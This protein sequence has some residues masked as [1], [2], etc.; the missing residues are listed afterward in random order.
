MSTHQHRSGSLKQANKG[1]KRSHS[2]K[3]ALK[4]STPGRVDTARRRSVKQGDKRNGSLKKKNR[5]KQLKQQKLERLR[6]ERR[7]GGG[8]N[9][10][11][12]V[13]ILPL[14]E[15]VD[16][17]SLCSGLVSSTGTKAVLSPLGH[18]T[19]HSSKLKSRFT[20]L[21]VV[22][23]VAAVLDAAKAADVL[24][25]VLPA[26]HGQEHCIDQL[27]DDCIS[28]LRSQGLPTVIC[29]TTGLK[30]LPPKRA[31]E[32]RRYGQRLFKTEFGEDV[33]ILEEGNYFQVLRALADARLKQMK[34]RS[35]RPYIA[36]DNLETVSEGIDNTSGEEMVTVR[37]SGY[38]RGAAMTPNQLVHITDVGT[39]KLRQIS[40]PSDPC[41]HNRRDL[42]SRNKENRAFLADPSIVNDDLLRSEAVPTD[43]GCEQTWPTEQEM[44]MNYDDGESKSDDGLTRIENTVEEIMEEE[45]V[46]IEKLREAEAEDREFEDEVDTPLDQPAAERF[47]RYR[48]LKSF[49]T[50]P[51]DVKESLPSEYAR[52][53]EFEDF[54]NMQKQVLA[55][56]RARQEALT[57]LAALKYKSSTKKNNGATAKDGMEIEADTER[58][59]R[60]ARLTA[61]LDG[62]VHPGTY[63]CVEICNVPLAA[64]SPVLLRGQSGV[65]MLLS[66]LLEHEQ[67]ASVLHFNVQRVKTFDTPLKAKQLLVFQCGFRRFRGRPIFSAQSR[68]C[69]KHK[70]LRFCQPGGWCVASTFGPITYG[71]APVTVFT[72]SQEL[73][74]VGSLLNVDPD[75]VNLKRI[76]LTGIPAKIHKKVAII[77]KMFFNPADIKW[78][79]PIELRTK[80]G[81]VG[82]IL[83]SVGTH[84]SMKA[85]FNKPI[86]N[87]D[88]V[89]MYL[90]KRVYPKPA[91]RNSLF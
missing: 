6:A 44:M 47:A 21:P 72:E 91:S 7:L 74:L 46:D 71:P 13:G 36:A 60:I 41:P 77:T 57:A 24:L 19:I 42:E 18:A 15:D 40:T 8:S 34:W 64:L 59:S 23:S 17:D 52:I 80:Y 66:G 11:K 88:T 56:A 67:R 69:D 48:G 28:A 2:S 73:A 50:S 61:I 39:F 38:L 4:K 68:N 87:H 76:I 20:V 63:V 82:N 55:Q 31:A 58:Q 30:Q 22:R 51:W 70:S 14:A 10:P 5:A 1:H 25:V 49:R 75:R 3:R 53:F 45:N 78:F 27:A 84:G 35:V 90:Y 86:K 43:D 62:Y 33:K 65:T 12:I 37:M 9:A 85:T 16:M 26:Q 79:K 32:M 54:P 83:D 29:L 89:C 81:M